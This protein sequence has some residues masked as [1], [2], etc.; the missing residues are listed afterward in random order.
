MRQILFILVGCGGIGGNIAAQLPKLLQHSPHKLMLV[1]GDAIEESNTDRQPYQSQHVGMNKARILA[2]KINSFYDLETVYLDTFVTNRELS[3]V[4]RKYPDHHP[5]LIGALDN[6]P[7]RKLL[8]SV[9]KKHDS[10][11][12]IDAANSK[13]DGNIYVALKRHGTQAGMLRG[14]IYDLDDDGHPVDESCETALNKGETQFLITN[15]KIA[16]FVLEHVHYLL[17]DHMK[18]G[19]TV[20]ERLKTFHV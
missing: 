10:I 15:N 5:C 16:A 1:D 19:V 7:S 20:V 11:S 14:D 8:E 4:I 18:E 17:F 2:R 9:F 12:Y 6:D 13:Y 3:E